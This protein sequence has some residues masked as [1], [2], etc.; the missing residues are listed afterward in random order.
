MTFGLV[1]GRKI[2]VIFGCKWL[3]NIDKAKY[4]L[5]KTGTNL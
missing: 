1:E 5:I 4:K 3:K 2:K